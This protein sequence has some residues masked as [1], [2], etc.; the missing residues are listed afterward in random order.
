MFLLQYQKKSKSIIEDEV[1][2]DHVAHPATMYA[3]LRVCPLVWLM[4]DATTYYF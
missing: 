2:S 3:G 1:T 4:A